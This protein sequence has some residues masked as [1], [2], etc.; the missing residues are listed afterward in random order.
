MCV[1]DFE[2]MKW[3]K[4]KISGTVDQTHTKGE[5][6]RSYSHERMGRDLATHFDERLFFYFQ[7]HAFYCTYVRKTN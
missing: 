6:S 5:I 1:K 3:D 2:F 4:K 7:K